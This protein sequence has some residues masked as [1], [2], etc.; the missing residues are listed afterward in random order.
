MAGAS[1]APPKRRATDVGLRTPAVPRT[2]NSEQRIANSEYVP[3]IL[4]LS[5]R[6]DTPPSAALGRFVEIAGKR[7]FP[8]F[9]RLALPLDYGQT[10]RRNVGT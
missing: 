10:A 6:E 2:A 4:R 8:G 7:R 3:P 1:D 5:H 9:E